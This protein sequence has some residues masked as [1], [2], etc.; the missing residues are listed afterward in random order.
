MGQGHCMQEK[1]FSLNYAKKHV[2]TVAEMIKIKQ[3][4]ADILK[5]RYAE[6]VVDGNIAL[7]KVA[8]GHWRRSK[9][10]QIEANQI[11]WKNSPFGGLEI[12]DKS[13]DSMSLDVLLGR[14]MRWDEELYR[15]I[16]AIRTHEFSNALN[17]L[18][19]KKDHEWLSR[20]PLEP[21]TINLPEV[22]EEHPTDLQ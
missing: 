11:I 7:C 19:Y 17:K 2:Q 10:C 15:V 22:G 6:V 9:V 18:E 1:S 5:V 12:H 4:F 16:G 8:F 21:V 14:V 13:D 3:S 20:V